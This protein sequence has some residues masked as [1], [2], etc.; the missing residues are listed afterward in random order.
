MNDPREVPAAMNNLTALHDGGGNAP[1]DAFG[2][3]EE[4]FHIQ[5]GG[6]WGAEMGFQEA[7]QFRN[8]Q[9]RPR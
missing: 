8:E 2:Q 1:L 9:K 3:D 7:E 6:F 5:A 4:I